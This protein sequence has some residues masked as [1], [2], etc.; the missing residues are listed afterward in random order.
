MR[1]RRAAARCGRG[2]GHQIELLVEEED[3]AWRRACGGRGACTCCRTSSSAARAPATRSCEHAQKDLAEDVHVHMAIVWK[4]CMGAR[5]VCGG[6]GAAQASACTAHT[7][8]PIPST[9]V[10]SPVG[11][12]AGMRVCGAGHSGSDHARALRACH[13]S[14]PAR[15]RQRWRSGSGMG[16]EAIACIGPVRDLGSGCSRWCPINSLTFQDTFLLFDQS[17]VACGNSKRYS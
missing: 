6:R 8:S 9:P 16:I 14:T 4:G 10:R 12:A 2:L 5:R 1:A 17:R 11:A 7:A 13:P 15:P 3:L